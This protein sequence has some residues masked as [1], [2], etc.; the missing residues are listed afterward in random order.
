MRKIEPALLDSY[1]SLKRRANS[2]RAEHTNG[3]TVVVVLLYRSSSTIIYADPGPRRHLGRG[4]VR[5]IKQRA[6]IG[7]SEVIEGG[8]RES[9]GRWGIGIQVDRAWRR[10]AA[11]IFMCVALGLARVPIF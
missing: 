1:E 10:G 3:D 5:G 2:I 7:G 11:K 4:R 9:I 8:G 6:P